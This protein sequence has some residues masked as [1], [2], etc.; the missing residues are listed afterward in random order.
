MRARR[1][2]A[3]RKN[4]F[5]LHTGA[6]GSRAMRG[7]LRYVEYEFF[8]GQ[9]RQNYNIDAVFCRITSGWRAK[10]ASRELYV[11]LCTLL[12]EKKFRKIKNH[13]L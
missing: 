9:D 11:F 7:F 13:F 12:P 4:L 2:P 1:V 10:R 6:E 3:V 8:R 5:S